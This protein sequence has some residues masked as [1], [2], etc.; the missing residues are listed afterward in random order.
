MQSELQSEGKNIQT[1][2]IYFLMKIIIKINS[3]KKK[4]LNIEKLKIVNHQN[5]MN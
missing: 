1:K 3:L 4:F 5:L 2:K